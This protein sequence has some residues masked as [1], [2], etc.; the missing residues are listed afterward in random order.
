MQ[1]KGC[2]A[3]RSS[4]EVDALIAQLSSYPCFFPQSIVIEMAIDAYVNADSFAEANELARFMAGYV[5]GMSSRQA[6]R[7][8]IAANSNSQIK[9][10]FG[11]RP[12]LDNLRANGKCS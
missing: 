2:Q 12:L 9:D 8:I 4:S 10:S 11:W 6:G 5:R 1:A 3:M 7:I